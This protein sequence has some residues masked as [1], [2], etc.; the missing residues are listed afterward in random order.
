METLELYKLLVIGDILR[1]DL[2]SPQ[3][4]GKLLLGPLGRQ[5]LVCILVARL[6]RAGNLPILLKKGLNVF[7]VRL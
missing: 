7:S 5:V 2:R 1:V 6:F 3:E 4:I